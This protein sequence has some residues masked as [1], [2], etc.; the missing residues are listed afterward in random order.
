MC[1]FPL[2]LAALKSRGTTQNLRKLMSTSIQSIDST[3]IDF[4]EIQ[5]SKKDITGTSTSS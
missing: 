5:F 4:N 1:F 3:E 2:Q